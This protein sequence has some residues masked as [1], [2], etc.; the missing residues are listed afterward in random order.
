MKTMDLASINVAPRRGNTLL[1]G[2][3]VFIFQNGCNLEDYVEE[4]LDTC[5]HASCDDI[6]LMEGFW[7]GLDDDIRIP[8]GD[9]YWILKDYIRFAR[10]G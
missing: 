9:P 7:C 5:H 1:S 8:R 10:C 2:G 3:T 4:F 6:C